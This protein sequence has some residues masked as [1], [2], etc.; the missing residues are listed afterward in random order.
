MR[1]DIDFENCFAPLELNVNDLIIICVNE[2][3]KRFNNIIISTV[4]WKYNLTWASTKNYNQSKKKL[5]N[6]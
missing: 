2:I 4:L 6:K 1:P 5:K 3:V